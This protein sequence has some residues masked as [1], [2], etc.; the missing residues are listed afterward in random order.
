LA[1]VFSDYTSKLEELKVEVRKLVER[2]SELDEEIHAMAGALGI[3][4]SR[5]TGSEPDWKLLEDML[6][7]ALEYVLKREWKPLARARAD[8]LKRVSQAL[9]Q[10]LPPPPRR[11]LRQ[12]AV[13]R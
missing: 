12:H 3:T 11:K 10:A 2:V 8:M 6:R 1:R 9:S 5:S 4:P 7:R 13:R